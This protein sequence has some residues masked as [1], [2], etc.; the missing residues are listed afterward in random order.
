MI[1][2]RDKVN[3]VS[4]TKRESSMVQIAFAKAEMEEKLRV[5]VLTRLPFLFAE[6]YQ[7]LAVLSKSE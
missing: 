3:L 5:L 2:E 7:K 6:S 1:E 4:Q